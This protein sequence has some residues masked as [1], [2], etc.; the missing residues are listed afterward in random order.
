MLRNL[1]ISEQSKR[2]AENLQK[3]KQETLVTFLRKIK[4]FESRKTPKLTH[5][6]N[7]PKTEDDTYKIDKR[8]IQ[9]KNK[10][11]NQVSK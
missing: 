8:R 11:L 10:T 9:F 2:E 1:P 7:R 5:P 6:S 3:R 4:S